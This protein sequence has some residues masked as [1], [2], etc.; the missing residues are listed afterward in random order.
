[1]ATPCRHLSVTLEAGDEVCT[2]CGLVLRER[3]FWSEQI[4][5][6]I[7]RPDAPTRAD[8]AL[9]QACNRIL[10]RIDCA[11][12]DV[13]LHARD[14]RSWRRLPQTTAMSRQCLAAAVVFSLSTERPAYVVRNAAGISVSQWG[15]TL[16]ALGFEAQAVGP[17]ERAAAAYESRRRG[18]PG[19]EAAVRA[20]L[21]A[22][23]CSVPQITAPRAATQFAA[24]LRRGLGTPG[25][26]VSWRSLAAPY[27]LDAHVRFCAGGG[28]GDS[29]AAHIARRGVPPE[30]CASCRRE[31]ERLHATWVFRT[32]PI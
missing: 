1:M 13:S 14:V 20:A 26:P 4:R 29:R 10:R 3:L 27:E 15:R 32:A 7:A 17:P 24:A 19:L 6:P 21:D 5:A 30:D 18:A 11:A 23:Q 2:D 25:T 31:A 8:Y 28:S 16:V 9:A 12:E 22:N